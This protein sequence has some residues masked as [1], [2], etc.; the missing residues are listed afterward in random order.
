[1][2]EPN[3]RDRD[4]SEVNLVELFDYLWKRK[5]IILIVVAVAFLSSYFISGN[6]NKKYTSNVLLAPASEQESS[7]MGLNA[8]ELGGLASLAGLN[9]GNRRVDPSQLAL[10]ILLSRKFLINFIKENELA[11]FLVAAESYNED[12]SEFNFNREIYDPETGSWLGAYQNERRLNAQAY[13]ELRNSIEYEWIRESGLLNVELVSISAQASKDWL[14]KLTT[15]LNYEMRQRDITEAQRSINFIE[16]KLKET[17]LTEIRS[18]L[19]RLIEDQTRKLMFADVREEYAFEVIDPPV[20]A[21]QP[22][23]PRRILIVVGITFFFGFLTCFI[24]IV[25]CLFQQNRR[26]YNS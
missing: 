12:L 19:Y 5:L 25:R 26:Y 6:L 14:E 7:N 23:F 3:L 15:S 16:N 24:L 13:R 1:M 10:S 20:E 4:L 21:T 18:I 8:P 11:P 22:S 2:N 17:E 9:V